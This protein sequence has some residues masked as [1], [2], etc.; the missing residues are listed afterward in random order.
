MLTGTGDFGAPGIE[1]DEYDFEPK[2]LESLFTE[3]MNTSISAGAAG[4]EA[5]QQI[6]SIGKRFY[7]TP[8]K[9]LGSIISTALNALALY[10]DPIVGKNTSRSDFK[11]S[12]L[13]DNDRPVSLYFITNP[14]DLIRMRPLARLLITR[15]VDSLCGEM[16]YDEGRSKA[17]HKHKLL[18]MLDEFPVLGKL[19]SFERALAYM[20]SYGI[21]AYIIMQDVQQL[22]QSY[23]NYE[24]ILSNCHIQMATAPN[25]QQTAEL[26]SKM[27]G[28][29]TVIKEQISVSGKR[30]G[31]NAQNFSSSFQETQRQLMTPDEVK[32]LPMMHTT[33]DAE[34]PGEMLVFIAGHPVIKGRQTPYFLDPT[35][36][37]R[38]K[39]PPP[40]ESDVVRKGGHPQ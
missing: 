13:M 3:M 6:N 10:R 31:G 2:P 26:L 19:E 15:I 32:H 21:K 28:Q 37:K 25:N 20:R 27:C 35:F 14:N 24:S 11:I 5:Q 39:I 1:K 7:E 16:E 34:T 38:S 8:S 4:A 9:E 36:D 22:Y 18:M 12:D 17:P 23:S 33:A 30:F 29:T 40:K